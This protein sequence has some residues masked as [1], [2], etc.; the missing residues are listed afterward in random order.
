M[1]QFW[2]VFRDARRLG[3]PLLTAWRAARKSS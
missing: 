2:F 3:F 1:R